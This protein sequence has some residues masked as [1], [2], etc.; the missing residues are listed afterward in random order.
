MDSD[1]FLCRLA[2]IFSGITVTPVSAGETGILVLAVMLLYVSGIVS[3]SETAFFSLSSSDRDKINASEHPADRRVK[4]LLDDSERLLA[5][6]L[7]S[8]NFMN[9]AVILLFDY[10]FFSVID[11]GSHGVMGFVLLTVVLT[12]LLLIFG[13]IVPKI[14]S[15]QHSLKVVR[16][17]APAVCLLR[18]VFSPLS[19]LLMRSSF[20]IK[21]IAFDKKTVHNISVDD[22]SQALELTGIED[23]PEESNMLEGIIR[24]GEETAKEV[25]TSR[26]DMVDIEIKTPFSGVLKCVVENGYSRIPVYEDSR[27]NIKGIL[28]IKDLL[29]YLGRGD[30]FK[31]QNLIRPALFVP[32]TKM[33]DDLLRDFQ[34]N[35]IH[36]AVV[37]DEFGGTSGIVTMED[38]IEEIV[39]EINDEYD[40]DER[41][42][43]KLSDNVY[44]FEAKTLLSDFY[45]IVK[46]DS[47][48]F[49]EVAGDSDTLAGLVLELKGEFPA[50]HEVLEH[51][52]FRFEVLEMNSRRILK[53]KVTILPEMPDG[54]ADREED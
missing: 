7:I 43:V 22:L 10:F 32:E 53:V 40:D 34:A 44:V 15:A 42:Y 36:I 48:E 31:W 2:D 52:N 12:V 1:Y 24:F 50:L 38:L 49:E 37:V 9:V 39:G 33:I 20:F 17:A 8:D 30:E 13:E 3:A 51:R 14:Y 25:M 16:K 35:K 27:D 4:S 19:A 46:V 18:A 23:T 21:R 47:D 5:T 6:I 41:T 26:L 11:F 45:K 29:P 28:Y 54:Q